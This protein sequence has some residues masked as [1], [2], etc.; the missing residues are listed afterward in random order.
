MVVKLFLKNL[1][2]LTK[3]ET[4]KLMRADRFITQTHNDSNFTTVEKNCSILFFSLYKL[5]IVAYP[6]HQPF[7]PSYCLP[8]ASHCLNAPRANETGAAPI[9]AFLQEKAVLH[10]PVRLNHTIACVSFNRS[11]FVVDSL[12]TDHCDLLLSQHCTRR[13][14]NIF[15]LEYIVLV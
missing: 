3:S 14:R 1:I 11:L 5:I 6:L 12:L 8:P 13:L 10:L 9:D 7:I 2:K 15:E 4:C